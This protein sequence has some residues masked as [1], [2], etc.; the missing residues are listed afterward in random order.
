M[1][2]NR[3]TTLDILRLIA[4][5]CVVF[6]H[7]RFYGNIG[8][9]VDAL[10]RFAVPLFLVI[11]GFYGYKSAPEKIKSRIMSILALLGM[12]VVAYTAF[13]VLFLLIK[14]D[15]QGI[16]QYFSQCVNFRNL[17]NLLVLNDPIH[18]EHLWYLFAIVYVYIIINLVTAFRLPEKLFFAICVILLLLHL[19]AAEGLALL[20]IVI[21]REYVRNFAFMGL[22]FFGMGMMVRKHVDK[23]RNVPNFVVAVSVVLGGA[24][25]LISQCLLGKQELYLGSLFLLFAIIVIFTKYPNGKYPQSLLALTGCSTYIYVF[26]PM[27]SDLLKEIYPY[28]RM[29]YHASVWLQMLHPLV[30]CIIS[31]VL[32]WVINKCLEKR[33]INSRS[34]S[35]HQ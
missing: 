2:Q 23:L 21:T 13:D 22:P 10:A 9:A 1:A 4:S 11:S 28:L 16:T 24:E 6:I 30:V 5:Y 14:Q 7:V 25:I 3:N 8:N 15:Y 17:R 19:L 33:K 31:T 27:V 12:A 18:T 34:N 32:A 20:H 29:N 26:H 35:V